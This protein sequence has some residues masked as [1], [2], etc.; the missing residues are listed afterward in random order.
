MDVGCGRESA[1]LAAVK[2][3]DERRER[4]VSTDTVNS[5]VGSRSEH[6][7]SARFHVFPLPHARLPVVFLRT[8]G[9]RDGVAA[10]GAAPRRPQPDSWYFSSLPQR[11][12][13]G[14]S[15]H[16]VRDVARGEI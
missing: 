10:S 9:T 3:R 15:T 16:L 1:L 11:S 8:C 13:Y 4:E 6:L 14:I 7:P 5:D 12:L 2:S